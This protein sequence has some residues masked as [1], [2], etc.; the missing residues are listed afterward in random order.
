MKKYQNSSS[1]SSRRSGR[2]GFWVVLIIV[3]VLMG[4]VAGAL[5]YHKHKQPEA[6]T[7]SNAKTAQN[8]YKDGDNRQPQ[9]GSG[10]AQG[11]ATDNKGDDT[12]TS[13]TAPTTSSSN[14]IVTVVGLAK[15]SQ[16]GSGDV[17]RG[18]VSD[19]T[20][21]QIQFR[22]IDDTVGVIA[23]G[24]L[25]VVNGNF[26]GTLSFTSHSDTGR[27]DVYS[28]DSMSSEINNVEIPVRFK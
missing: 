6:K 1:V 2:K 18:T 27:V 17:L 4:G 8:D 14:G 19:K 25:A 24:Q 20:V 22:V 16:V 10:H 26:S 23:Q 12:P 28:F 5:V 13:P 7:T 11:G 15:D 21:T 3:V 9:E